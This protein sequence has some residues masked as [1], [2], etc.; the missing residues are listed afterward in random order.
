MV[1]AVEMTR[2]ESLGN[3]VRRVNRVICH[4]CP[5][6]QSKVFQRCLSML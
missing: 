6:G 1:M 3:G 2:T 4:M 5:R